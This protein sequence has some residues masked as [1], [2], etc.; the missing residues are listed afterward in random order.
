MRIEFFPSGPRSWSPPRPIPIY[1][2]VATGLVFLGGVC[3]IVGSAVASEGDHRFR[4]LAFGGLG[5]WLAGVAIV[6]FFRNGNNKA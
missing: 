6:F 5:L 3:G 4:I 1:R 2:I